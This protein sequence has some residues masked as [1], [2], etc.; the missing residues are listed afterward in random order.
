MKVYTIPMISQ[1]IT[2]AVTLIQMNATSTRLLVLLGC[3]ITNPE[4][5]SSEQLGVQILKVTT[6]G[7]GTSTTPVPVEENQGAA[8]FTASTDHTAEG[9]ASTVHWS[10]SFNLVGAGWIYTPVPEARIWVPPSGRLAIKLATAP[11]ASINL[12]AVAEVGEV[13]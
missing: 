6:A 5:E 1:A 12:N 4:S 7:T 10:D 9:T 2:A 8:G 13:G 3:R 11:G